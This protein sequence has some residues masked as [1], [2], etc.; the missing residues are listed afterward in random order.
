ML[1]TDQARRPRSVSSVNN[2]VGSDDKSEGDDGAQLQA[3]RDET[4]ALREEQ[5]ELREKL[6]AT[7][8][9]LGELTQRGDLWRKVSIVNP[10]VHGSARHYSD[11]HTTTNHTGGI[12]GTGRSTSR[13]RKVRGAAPP[14]AGEGHVARATHALVACVST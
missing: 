13:N 3:M 10:N 14:G 8:A 12:D 9:E 7:E 6:A 1:D 4:L 2:E 11:S 5:E